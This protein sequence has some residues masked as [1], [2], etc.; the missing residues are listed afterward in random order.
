MSLD[1]KKLTDTEVQQSN[2]QILGNI[3]KE[4][5]KR[6]SNTK[7]AKSKITLQDGTFEK[8]DSNIAREKQPIP[9]EYLGWME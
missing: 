5:D 4:E 2:Q 7:E 8:S 9:V 6:Y 1:G 3:G